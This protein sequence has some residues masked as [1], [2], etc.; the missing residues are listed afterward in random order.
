[1]FILTQ[2]KF[3]TT[4]TQYVSYLWIGEP[5]K[6]VK[7][8]RPFKKM[9]DLRVGEVRVEAARSPSMLEGA[10]ASVM[11]PPMP[12]QNG[13]VVEGSAPHGEV[14]SAGP[15]QS[16]EWP[17]ENSQVVDLTAS[18]EEVLRAAEYIERVH[19]PS[20]PAV[21]GGKPRYLSAGKK[22]SLFLS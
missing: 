15:S 13:G 16:R 9:F 3:S 8:L 7:M 21:G 19:V 18:D 17:E 5:V 6:H 11:A 10:S 14:D 20:A 12:P 2:L 22:V 4:T 1:M